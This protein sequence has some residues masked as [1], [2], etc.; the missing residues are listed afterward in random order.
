MSALSDVEVE[1]IDTFDRKN[2]LDWGIS[3]AIYI[4]GKEVP[5][6]PPPTY[7][8]IRKMLE[9]RVKKLS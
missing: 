8:K 1:I 2:L 4:D 9:R 5:T 3:D 6:G 7:E